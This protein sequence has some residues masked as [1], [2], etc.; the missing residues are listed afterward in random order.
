MRSTTVRL[1]DDLLD[2]IIREEHETGVSKSEIVR[3]ALQAHYRMDAAQAT[4]ADIR[5]AISEHEEVHHRV[6]RQ[7]AEAV[8]VLGLR[9]M[10]YATKGHRNVIDKGAEE[11]SPARPG[12]KSRRR[13][14]QKI[15]FALRAHLEAKEEITTS[16]LARELGIEAKTVG[17]SLSKVGISAKNTRRGNVAGRYYVAEL[18]PAVE[19]AIKDLENAKSQGV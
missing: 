9:S 11:Q 8:G 7:S 3:L 15:L 19:Q 16:D 13:L 5:K 12:R 6:P 4:L 1:P 17:R 14:V 2:A 18:L 10:T